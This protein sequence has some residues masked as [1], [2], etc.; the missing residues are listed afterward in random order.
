MMHTN[1]D[2]ALKILERCNGCES[3]KC[4]S[5]ENGKSFSV[6][7]HEP[8][9]DKWIVEVDKCPKP[10]GVVIES[11]PVKPIITTAHWINPS[12]NPEFVNKDFFSDCSNCGNTVSFGEEGSVCPRCKALMTGMVAAG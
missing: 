6:C 9:T 3:C 4:V 8:Y 11:V 10:D 2:R 7:C 12:R 5:T 1:F